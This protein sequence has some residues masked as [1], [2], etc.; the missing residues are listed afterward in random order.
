MDRRVT[1]GPRVRMW[2]VY[3]V[4]LVTIVIGVVGL[5]QPDSVTVIR[6][7]YFASP[8]RIAA[9]GAF[10]LAMGLAL[11]LAAS[12]SRWPRLMRAF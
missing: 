8:A 9:A 4:A 12:A 7:M 10:R 6:R 3:L 2:A 5:V 1:I 11:V